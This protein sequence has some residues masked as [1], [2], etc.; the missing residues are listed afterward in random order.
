MSKTMLEKLLAKTNEAIKVEVT[1]GREESWK[2]NAFSKNESEIKM[3]NKLASAVN[4]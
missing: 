3:D 4:C 1:R 2:D